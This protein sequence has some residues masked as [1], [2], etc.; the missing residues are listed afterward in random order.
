MLN[1]ACIPIIPVIPIAT[2]DPNISGAFIAIT[3]PLHIKI[4]NNKITKITPTRPV[5]SAHVDNMKSLCGSAMYIYFCTPFP[6]PTPNKPPEPIAYNDCIICQPLFC[7]SCQ[8]SKNHCS[9]RRKR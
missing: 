6:N 8:G 2:N 1:I 9:H 3:I 5:S 4:A 7:G